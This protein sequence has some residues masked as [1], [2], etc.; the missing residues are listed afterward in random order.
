MIRNERT[1]V[2]RRKEKAGRG[3]REVREVRRI[4]K[5]REVEIL[6]L[7]FIQNNRIIYY[8]MELII[9]KIFIIGVLML[10]LTL[11]DVKINKK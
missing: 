3:R 9:S 2:M 7:D 1:M 6:H 5:D 8:F 4:G 10:C 11:R